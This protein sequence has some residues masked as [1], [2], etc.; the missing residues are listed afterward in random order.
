MEDIYSSVKYTDVFIKQ[1]DIVKFEERFIEVAEK[2][3]SQF[4]KRSTLS[5]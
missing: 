4:P 1:N 5:R 2:F 3:S